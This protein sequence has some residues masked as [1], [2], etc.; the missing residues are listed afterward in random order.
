MI[1]SMP[2]EVPAS[3][4]RNA[5]LR[6]ELR[7][8]SIFWVL[9][10]VI[11]LI[12]LLGIAGELSRNFDATD[13]ALL[14]RTLR[15]IRRN[16]NPSAEQ[17]AGAW[18]STA[19][20]LVSSFLFGIIAAASRRTGERYATHWRFLAAIALFLS[21]DEAT[22]FHEQLGDWVA[23]V[24]PTGGIFLWAWVIPYTF[25]AGGVMLASISW[26]RAL[27]RGT[28]RDILVAGVFYVGGS[29]GL[30]MLQAGI[31][32]ARGRGGG[33][34]TVLAVIEETAEMIGVAYLIYALMRHIAAHTPLAVS[35]SASSDSDP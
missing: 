8:Q 7:P 9:L 11:A 1:V 13:R 2:P 20:L 5:R 32:D 15:L 25:F 30:E 33:P 19:A 14:P 3:P 12:T 26:L 29:L 31:T 35:I 23:R 34:V 6:I 27:P 18:F 22:A 17:T 28:R 24:L 4:A 10:G 21:Y 16:F